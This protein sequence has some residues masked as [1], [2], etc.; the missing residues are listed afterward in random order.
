MQ[1][2][3]HQHMRIQRGV[4]MHEKWPKSAKNSQNANDVA[5]SWLEWC[6]ALG[7]S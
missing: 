3:L 7:D 4:K 2:K 1:I 6:P 5:G